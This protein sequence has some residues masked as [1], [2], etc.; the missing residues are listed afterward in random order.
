MIYHLLFILFLISLGVQLGFAFFYYDRI[1][2]FKGCTKS[3]SQ[4]PVSVVVCTHNRIGSLRRLIDKLQN[5]DY[6]FYELIVVND[7]SNDSTAVY[8][9]DLSDE[10]LITYINVELTPSG[11]NSKKYALSKGIQASSHDLILLTDDDCY[12][13]SNDWIKRMVNGFEKDFEIVLGYSQYEAGSGWLNRF[14]R[15][16]TFL[17]GMNYLSMA[18]AGFPYM[19]VGRNLAFR[20]TLFQRSGGYHGYESVTGGDDDLFVNKNANQANTGVCIGSGSLTFSMPKQ[21]I[22]SYFKQKRRHLSVGKMYKMSDKIRIGVQVLTQVLLWATFVILSAA[23]IQSSII[24]VGFLLRII[25]NGWA[26]L[27][28][29]RKLGDRYNIWYSPFLDFLYTVYVVIVGISAM[30]SKAIR[31]T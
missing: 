5:Q 29:A 31:W 8:L 22:M 1:L 9:K 12:P 19:G 7:R 26:H 10:H 20:K 23:N 27:R 6:E 3:A 2:G 11:Y 30:N 17:T 18:L 14:I 28:I 24:L 13:A 21:E 4:P 16:E 15:Y 25:V